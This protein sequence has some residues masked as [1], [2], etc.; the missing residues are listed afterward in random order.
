MF[1]TFKTQDLIYVQQIFKSK[2]IYKQLLYIQSSWK[3][4]VTVFSYHL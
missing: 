3:T 1:G 4:D 2:L